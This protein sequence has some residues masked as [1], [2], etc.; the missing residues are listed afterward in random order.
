[1]TSRGSSTTSENIEVSLPR[2]MTWLRDVPAPLWCWSRA[3]TGPSWKRRRAARLASFA[4]P[5]SED[6]FCNR[7]SLHSIFPLRCRHISARAPYT[8]TFSA[9]LTGERGRSRSTSTTAETIQYDGHDDHV[10][11]LS[12]CRCSSPAHDLARSYPLGELR[13]PLQ[14][15]H[16]SQ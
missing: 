8:E 13:L 12:L 9:E 1:M 11:P 6:S 10:S 3:S 2:S 16:S 7:P 4:W 15:V 14:R 5:Q